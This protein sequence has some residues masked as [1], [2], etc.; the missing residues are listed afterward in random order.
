MNS[1]RLAK[2]LKVWRSA[3]LDSPVVVWAVVAG[4]GMQR[5]GFVAVLGPDGIDS[6][7]IP[8]RVR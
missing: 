6:Y 4:L 5:I 2:S 1:L 7:R 8:V 3:D